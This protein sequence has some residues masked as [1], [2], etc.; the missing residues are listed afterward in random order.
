M[1]ELSWCTRILGNFRNGSFDLKGPFNEWGSFLEE[2]ANCN[3]LS[4][5]HSQQTL[6]DMM[7]LHVN[8]QQL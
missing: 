2:E 8:N 6:P 4:E 5:L 7:L 3:Q 1:R